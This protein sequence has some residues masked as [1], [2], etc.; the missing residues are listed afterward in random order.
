MLSSRSASIG[1]DS[2]R[3]ERHPNVLHDPAGGLGI[4]WHREWPTREVVMLRR[5]WVSALVYSATTTI[6]LCGCGEGKKGSSKDAPKET[7][8]VTIG[9]SLLTRTHPFYQDLEA[10]LVEGAA[11]H[12]YKL[13]IQAGEFDV[14]KQKDQLENFIVGKVNAI[15]VCPCDSNRSGPPSR[16]RTRRG[17]PSSPPTSLSSPKG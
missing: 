16:R 8:G 11:E 10:G 9:V 7:P 2:G 15:I 13:L 17:S 1:I 14:A 6:L 3:D 12:G 4:A 5:Q